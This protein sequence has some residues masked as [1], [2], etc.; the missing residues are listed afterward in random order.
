[1]NITKEY[2]E[3]LKPCADRWENYLKHY[4]EWSG[5]LSQFLDLPELSH[6]DK[7]WVFVRSV[8][9]YKLKFF[10]AD[11]AQ[12]VLNLFERRFPGDDRP[13]KAIDAAR[14]AANYN[15]AATYADAAACAADAAAATYAAAAGYAAD[16]AGYAAVAAIYA[17]SNAAYTAA[18]ANAARKSEEL[19]QIEFMKRY[20]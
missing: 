17:N 20:A 6:R 5:T 11:C 18:D 8:D 19:K 4:S 3:S 12:S 15:S 16:A 1:M 13:R 2:L 14:D 9:K 10:A 7:V